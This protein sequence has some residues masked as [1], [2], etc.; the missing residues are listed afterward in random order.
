VGTAG[1]LLAALIGSS[2]VC[3]PGLASLPSGTAQQ[4][5]RSASGLGLWVI[6]KRPS[7]NTGQEAAVRGRPEAER[8]RESTLSTMRP[9]AIKEM[10]ER[11][12]ASWVGG[13]DSKDW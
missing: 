3:Q 11:M 4:D 2:L 9:L 13:S 7:P 8:V 6:G 12:Q 5:R 1:S 10:Q